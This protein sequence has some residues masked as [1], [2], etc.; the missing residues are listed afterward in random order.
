MVIAVTFG[1]FKKI[2][3]QG[4]NLA[5]VALA[6]DGQKGGLLE[7]REGIDAEV[8]RFAKAFS[9]GLV[10]GGSVRETTFAILGFHDG[11]LGKFQGIRQGSWVGLLWVPSVCGMVGR[12]GRHVKGVGGV[13]PRL[14]WL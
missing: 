2:F 10:I 4:G 13:R 3:E 12:L 5:D 9:E 7:V 14:V 1:L 11:A 6:C 8:I